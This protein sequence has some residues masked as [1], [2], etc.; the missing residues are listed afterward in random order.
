MKS[1]FKVLVIVLLVLVALV[2]GM[3]VAGG[4]WLKNYRETEFAD[5]DFIIPEGGVTEMIQE[6]ENYPPPAAPE[7]V[8][9]EIGD[10]A[11]TNA[12]LQVYFWAQV[13]AHA[14]TD[15][16]QPDLRVPLKW[17][18]C[19]LEG[20]ENWEEYF[21]LK[22][23]NTWHTAQA[24]V[25][26]GDAEGLPL[27]ERY[28]PNLDWHAEYMTGEE[29]A[30]EFLYGWNPG[31]RVNT[32]HQNYIDALPA[33]LDD[34]A[35]GLDYP[36]SEDMAM[37]VFGTTEEKVL[38]AASLYN[39][40]YSYYTALTYLLGTEFDTTVEKPAEDEAAE[41]TPTPTPTP[42]PAPTVTP[43]PKYDGTPCISFRQI[44][45]R[46][47]HPQ[48]YTKAQAAKEPQVEYNVAPDGKVSC[49]NSGWRNGDWKSQSIL[50][51]WRSDYQSTEYGFGQLAYERSDDEASAK[52]GGL[53]V[54]VLPGEVPAE[55][56]EWLF[57]PVRKY[58]DT[59]IIRTEYGYHILYFVE[60]TTVEAKAEAD[61]KLADKQAELI[62]IAKERFPVELHLEAA[63]MQPGVGAVTLDELLYADIAHERYPEVPVYLQRDYGDTMY[64]AYKLWSHGCGITSMAMLSTYLTDEEWT[65]PELCD[66]FGSY[67][68]LHGTD[69]SLFWR[70]N[71]HLGFF[72]ERYVYDDDEAYQAL[73]DGY[74][75]V[76]QEL[77]GY[78]TGG[79]H[80]IV[81]E[82]LT[83]DGKVVVRDSNILNYIKL[84]GHSVDYFDWDLITPEAVIYFIMGKK[85]VTVDACCRC[86]DPTEQSAAQV[87]SDYICHK[88]DSAMLRRATFL[89]NT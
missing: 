31:Y 74:L 67:C 25:M 78:W 60:G 24:L 12:E 77:K 71:H 80:Y 65:P 76:A 47:Q 28:Q 69:T 38:Q 46:P 57:D 86:G 42:K 62:A 3:V 51:E 84:E 56:E 29:P 27:E 79:G 59:K 37:A 83:E 81:L 87:G 49:V 54:N 21:L 8:V 34:L 72:Y 32:L 6:Y 18:A 63:A 48:W 17:Q 2:V 53:Y 7:A 4:L 52:H 64:G 61:A 88:C 16:V 35:E 39:R 50:S 14:R 15:E 30:I 13:A 75:V 5:V 82:K 19:P 10:T 1:K 43:E 26:Q 40:G 11:L 55:L 9:A 44:L 66:M 58:G 73:E 85:A 70:A 23:V 36:S 68:G 20:A 41:P 33:L 22:A 45:H 89:A